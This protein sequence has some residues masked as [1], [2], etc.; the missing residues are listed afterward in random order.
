MNLL[1][2][3]LLILLFQLACSLGWAN[4]GY[5]PP[6]SFPVPPSIPTQ[7]ALIKFANGEQT[8][9]VESSMQSE[10]GDL[11]AWILPLPAVPTELG[12]TTPG[13]LKTMR[14]AIGPRIVDQ[15]QMPS[16]LVPGFLV[17]CAA[18]ITAAFLTKQEKRRQK[19]IELLIVLVII[20]FMS[21]ISVSSLPG[22]HALADTKVLRQEQVGNY[23]TAVILAS[24]SVEMNRWLESNG[25]AALPS[26]SEIAIKQYIEE[27]WCFLASKLRRNE[28][29]LLMPH[30][31][32]VV[33]PAER[34]VYPMRLTAIGGGATTIDLFVIADRQ[35]SAHSFEPLCADQFARVSH[36]SPLGGQHSVLRSSSGMDLGHPLALELC[37]DGDWITRLSATVTPEQM[38]N[39]VY[40]EAISFPLPYRQEYY[41]RKAAFKSGLIPALYILAVLIPVVGIAF[42]SDA[43]HAP[44]GAAAVLCIPFFFVIPYMYFQVQ[45]TSDVRTVHHFQ[46][47]ERAYFSSLAAH[48]F[49]SQTGAAEARP[50]PKNVYTGEPIREGDG[51]GEYLLRKE[52]GGTPFILVHDASGVP[53]R[54][55][56]RR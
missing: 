8:L 39:D 23:E 2:D 50:A 47:K 10:T 40:L 26:E 44:L 45:V 7:T 9:I 24:S 16:A 54:K 19:L 34:P 1:R 46:A 38:E 13:F 52:E 43:D 15:G 20:V 53:I 30:P 56:V 32:K 6:A 21:G 55:K 29:G 37:K 18:L 41:T 5:I 3:V 22:S 33:F 51:P 27:G 17:L 36:Y 49:P 14:M 11:F 25:F 28:K 12:A 48:L 4:G 35:Y 42:R 31:L